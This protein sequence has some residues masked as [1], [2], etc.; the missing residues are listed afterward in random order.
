[1]CNNKGAGG[2][3]RIPAFLPTGKSTR[4]RRCARSIGRPKLVIATVVLLGFGGVAYGYWTQTGSGTGSAE[5][6]TGEAITINQTSDI[7]GLAPGVAPKTL[8]GTFDNR[9]TVRSTSAA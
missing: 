5:T 4:R 6:G 2:L 9:T 1:V 7:S 8:S 3:G